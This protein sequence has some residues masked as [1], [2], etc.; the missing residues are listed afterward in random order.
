M[1]LKEQAPESTLARRLGDTAH[2]PQ[3]ETTQDVDVIIPLVQLN[4][5]RADSQFWDVRD[6]KNS[7]LPEPK[8]LRCAFH[9]A[10]FRVL[11]LARRHLPRP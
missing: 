9:A 11:H 3:H 10:Q 2:D 7:E 6:A 8:E 5:L 4:L 1:E